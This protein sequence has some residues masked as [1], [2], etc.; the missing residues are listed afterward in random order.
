MKGDL[1]LLIT[2]SRYVDDVNSPGK[3]NSKNIS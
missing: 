2:Y 3:A 1:S